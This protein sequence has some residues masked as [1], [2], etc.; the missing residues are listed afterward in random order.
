M[1][2][3]QIDPRLAKKAEREY[4]KAQNLD[5]FIPEPVVLS[6]QISIFTADFMTQRAE[7]KALTKKTVQADSDIEALLARF[8]NAREVLNKS[9]EAATTAPISAQLEEVK[10]LTNKMH[11]IINRLDEEKEVPFGERTVALIYI[12]SN[13]VL[14]QLQPMIKS[15]PQRFNDH[16]TGKQPHYW[17]DTTTQ[18]LCTLLN[19]TRFDF[20]LQTAT[21]EEKRNNKRYQAAAASFRGKTGFYEALQACGFVVE[22]DVQG[23]KVRLKINLDWIFAFSLNIFQNPDTP[24]L[25]PSTRGNSSHLLQKEEISSKE[26][27][28]NWGSGVPPTS[29][30]ILKPT[31]VGNNEEESEEKKSTFSLNTKKIEENFSAAPPENLHEIELKAANLVAKEYLKHLGNA[32]NLKNGRIRYSMTSTLDTT[33]VRE[34][35]PQDL[36]DLPFWILPSLQALR[37]PGESLTDI[38]RLA[39]QA[40]RNTGQYALNH[41]TRNFYHPRFWFNPD[42]TGGSFNTY[43]EKWLRNVEKQPEKRENTLN[44]AEIIWLIEAGAERRKL[45]NYIRKHGEET[46]VQV[47]QYAKTRIQRLDFQPINGV[48][49]Y[50]FGVL[51]NMKPHLIAVHLEKEQ[52]LLETKTLEAEGKIWTLKRVMQSANSIATNSPAY[53]LGHMDEAIATRI[54]AKSN[55]IKASNAQVEMWIEAILS[56]RKTQFNNG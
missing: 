8:D 22:K 39:I 44:N 21:T 4:W 40:I 56:G 29:S 55:D 27:I 19:R 32:K 35:T 12:L 46:V 2:N 26:T 45:Q 37:R 9:R 48:V 5:R 30:Q 13:I 14:R 41:P 15:N 52:K 1:E 47:I 31:I 20:D 33:I 38:T 25:P 3:I 17:L 36:N 16:A 11:R 23:N 49:A 53:K 42:F 24:F 6:K 51:K 43:V 54:A 18:A 10:R 28:D 34:L 50:I 7:R